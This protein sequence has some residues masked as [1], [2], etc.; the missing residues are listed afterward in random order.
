VNVL[1]GVAV[2]GIGTIWMASTLA[3]STL[4][5]PKVRVMAPPDGAILL[6]TS[7]TALKAPPAAKTMSKLVR[8]CVPLM[9]TLKTRCP[10]ADQ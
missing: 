1:V 6:K 4:A 5:G 8:T 9:A 7:S 10:A 3:W 2:V